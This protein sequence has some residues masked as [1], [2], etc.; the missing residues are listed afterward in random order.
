MNKKMNYAKMSVAERVA[1]VVF[2][3]ALISP[4]LSLDIAPLGWLALLP[5]AAVYPVL[6]GV[7]G[8]DPM[9]GVLV[10][11][12]AYRLFAGI[13]GAGLV[14]SALIAPAIEPAAPLGA[15]AILPLLGIYAVL[16]AL[17]G[18][19]PMAAVAEA[20][21]T[22]VYIVPPAGDEDVAEPLTMQGS[23]RNAA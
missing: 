4:V 17:L 20:T 11:P 6:T 9:R 18:R 5:L 8:H 2:G 14:A 1:R 10:H 23:T 21:R 19:A 15:I 16:A 22:I 12:V 3:A 7:T 13:L